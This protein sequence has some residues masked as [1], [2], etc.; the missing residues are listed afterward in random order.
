[1]L[2]SYAHTLEM[3]GRLAQAVEVYREYLV[4]APQGEYAAV[5]LCNTAN[6]MFAMKDNVSA[7]VL[8]RQVIEKEPAR[9]MH[10]CH[11]A[12]LLLAEKRFDAALA[13]IEKGLPFATEPAVAARLHED[14][15]LIYIEQ[16]RGLAALKAAEAAIERGACGIRAH[17]LRSQAL[18]MLGRLTEARQCIGRVLQMDPKNA[19]ALR[20]RKMLDKALQ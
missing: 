4:T 14:Q 13:L 17:Y 20:A 10:Y 5:A 1:L 2:I 15:A 8:Y 19:D 12:D 11:Y 6:C 3:M 16:R 18:A 7:E 9:A